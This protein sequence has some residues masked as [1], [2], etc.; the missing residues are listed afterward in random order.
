MEKNAAFEAG[1]ESA[2][3]KL[4]AKKWG[5]IM[6]M[7]TLR[8][9][10]A[11]EGAVLGGL[12]GGGLGALT[13]KPGERGRGAG[14]GAAAGALTGAIGGG[15]ATGTG[16]GGPE[17]LKQMNKLYEKIIDQ[18]KKG[19]RLDPVEIKAMGKKM[20]ENVK[21]VDPGFRRR[22]LLATYGAGGLAGGL[23]GASTR[24]GKKDQRR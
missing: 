17:Q 7:G 15:I 21:K 12:A 19:K 8:A 6:G 2:L 4:A 23:A 1:L 14:R 3:E 13:A 18:A 16:K 5:P 11:G 24:M 10:S 22:N 20:R 9:M